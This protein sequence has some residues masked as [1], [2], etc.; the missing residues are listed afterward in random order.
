MYA[1][2]LSGPANL[3]LLDS[4]VAG[5]T[6]GSDTAVQLRYGKLGSTKSRHEAL[7]PISNFFQT[8]DTW[9]VIVPRQGTVDWTGICKVIGKPELET[10]PRFDSPKNRRANAA[11][12]TRIA[13]A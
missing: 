3:T 1:G 13:A 10:D 9:I 8:K 5:N 11:E 6:A 7:M 2:C 12:L 4:T